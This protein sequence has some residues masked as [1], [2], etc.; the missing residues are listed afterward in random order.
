MKAAAAEWAGRG[1]VWSRADNASGALSICSGVRVWPAEE[2][3]MGQGLGD[4]VARG[5]C[6]QHACRYT[7][8]TGL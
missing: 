1:R 3:V 7:D 4:P 8:G 6:G 5:L 2:G